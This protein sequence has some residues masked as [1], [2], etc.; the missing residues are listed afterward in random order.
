[1]VI[2]KI[3]DKYN[4]ILGSQS[5]RRKK[6]LEKMNLKFK[7]KIC[8]QKEIFP[9]EINQNLIS[10]FLAKQKANQIALQLKDNFLLITADTIVIQNNNILHKPKTSIEVIKHLE[11]LSNEQ[12]QVITGVCIKSK[13]KEISFSCS[14]K[15]YFSKLEKNEIYSY[16]KK[17]FPYDKAGAYGIQDWIGYIGVKKIHGS[18]NNVVGLP[19]H[20]LY[21]NLKLFI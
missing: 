3:N 20:L 7:I 1:M 13:E 11:Q 4:I 8:K 6:L 15:V 18:F 17:Y 21:Q 10:E 14:T 5:S 2:E 16:I 12:H 9:K 19:T